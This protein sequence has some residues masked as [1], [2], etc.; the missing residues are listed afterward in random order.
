M[1]CCSRSCWY[2]SCKHGTRRSEICW[3]WLNSWAETTIDPT[4]H[5]YI[6]SSV[7]QFPTN[8]ANSC[9]WSLQSCGLWKDPDYRHIPKI[10]CSPKLDG[11]FNLPCTLLVTDIA[12]KG[13]PVNGHFNNKMLSYTLVGSHAIYTMACNSNSAADATDSWLSSKDSPHQT[14][15]AHMEKELLRMIS[16]KRRLVVKIA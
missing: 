6:P 4:K 16:H 9:K 11:V 15:R 3:L 2:K 12:P 8:T 10:L 7:H 14:I 13:S 1:T 5:H